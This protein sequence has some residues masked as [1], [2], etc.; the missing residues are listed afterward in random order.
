VVKKKG[1]C[2][3]GVETLVWGLWEK[4]A[5][6]RVRWYRASTTGSSVAR[7]REKFARNLIEKESPKDL[8]KQKKGRKRMGNGGR[9]L[10]NGERTAQGFLRDSPRGGKKGGQAMRTEEEKKKTLSRSPEAK[11]GC[12]IATLGR[13]NQ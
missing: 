2:S 1:K 10:A 6:D 5:Y 3:S 11:K 4:G 13:K 7:N 12:G 9:I 8:T